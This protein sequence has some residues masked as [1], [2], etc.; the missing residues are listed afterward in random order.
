V[1]KSGSFAFH[2]L[3]PV[4]GARSQY[5]TLPPTYLVNDN[6]SVSFQ[7]RLGFTTPDQKAQVQVST[8]NGVNW[9]VLYNQDG[10]SDNPETTWRQRTVS[11][12]N[13]AGKAVRLRFALEFVRGIFVSS[14]DLNVGW[15]LDDI[16]F[17]NTQEIVN[18]Q[19]LPVAGSTFQFHPEVVGDFSLQARAKTGHDFLDWG[20]TISVRAAAASGA[21]ELN[22]SLITPTAGQLQLNVSLTAGATPAKLTIESRD[23]LN[24]AWQT[25]PT[26]LQSVSSTQ[27]RATLAPPASER[28]KFYRV[29]AE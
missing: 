1:V 23:T 21:A 12:T 14:T 15:L 19:V 2:L 13:Y 20:P 9:T 6:A 24:T 29:R 22:L 26:A 28:T 4:D 25:D 27:F 5:I 11:L 18:S 7:S 16:Q 3:T 10:N 8:D 17:A